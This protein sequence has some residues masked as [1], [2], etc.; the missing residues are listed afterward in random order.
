MSQHTSPAITLRTLPLPVRLVLTTF[1]IAVGLGYFWGMAQ[2]HFKHSSGGDPLP[3][4][5]AL[6]NRF[7]GQPWPR[8]ERDETLA[9]V[10]DARP[11]IDTNAPKVPGVKIKSIIN[12]RCVVCHGKDGEKEDVLFETYEQIAKYFE[13]KVQYP[14]GHFYSVVTG[15]RDP[16]HKTSGW[17]R[18]NMVRAFFE[19]SEDWDDVKNQPDIEKQRSAEQTAVIA[20]LD[21]G[22]PEFSYNEDAFPLSDIA[23]GK[24]ITEKFRTQATKLPKDLM[25]PVPKAVDPFKQAKAKQLSVDGLTQSTHAHL[26]SFAMLWAL[27]GLIFAVTSYP[28]VIKCILAPLVLIFQVIDISCWWLARL[29][30]PGPYFAIAIAGTGAVVGLGLGLQIMLSLFNMYSF[31]GKVVLAGML[32]V[33]MIGFGV[34]AKKVVLPQLEEEKKMSEQRS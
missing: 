16:K 5:T 24:V 28:T 27:T 2:I 19:K 21:D 13:K 9:V 7:S 25:I 33:G 8:I 15:L 14:K 26:L 23:V 4:V 32:L 30:G 20:W 3:G 18:N 29:E 22:A 11:R 12:T 17:G 34:V 31:K 6:V 1:L 10:P